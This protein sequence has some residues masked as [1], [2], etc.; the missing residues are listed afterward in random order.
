LQTGGFD[1]KGPVMVDLHKATP[2]LE[3]T[4]MLFEQS[5]WYHIHQSKGVLNVNQQY[6]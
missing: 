3:I 1:L 2:C 6:L 5:F 4:L